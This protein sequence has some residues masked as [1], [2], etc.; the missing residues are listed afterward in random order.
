MRVYAVLILILLLTSCTYPQC[1][2]GNGTEGIVL[3]VWPGPQPQ[4]PTLILVEAQTAIYV[5][6]ASNFVVH[7]GDR[8][9]F[10][11]I[12]GLDGNQNQISCVREKGER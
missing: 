6:R 7:E 5:V 4:D 1:D 11:P 10:K 8:V 9:W 3:E 12:I 2:T